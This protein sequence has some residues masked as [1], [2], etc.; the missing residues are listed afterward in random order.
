MKQVT[1]LLDHFLQGK[2]LT[3]AAY[4]IHHRNTTGLWPMHRPIINEAM[5]LLRFEG[6]PYEQCEHIVIGFVHD[7]LIANLAEEHTFK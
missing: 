3:R 1:E 2:M 5:A 7:K 4:E 6:Y